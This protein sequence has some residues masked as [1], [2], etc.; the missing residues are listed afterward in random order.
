M[1]H[2]LKNAAAFWFY[3]LALLLLAGLILVKN[4]ILMLTLPAFL[5]SLDL[6]VIIAALIY[7]ASALYLS[8]SRG[9]TSVV[10]G[11]IIGVISLAL[12]GFLLY[13]N[14]AFTPQALIA[15]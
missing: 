3:L 10:L 2:S 9:K 4:G 5:H 1:L 12:L 11:A 13:L 7:G 6:P 15:I 14:F 8:L